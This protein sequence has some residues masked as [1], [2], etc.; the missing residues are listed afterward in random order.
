MT[1]EEMKARLAQI[2]AELGEYENLED[3][4]DEQLESINALHEESEGL[5]KKIETKEKLK[6]TLA[7]ANTSKRQTSA[8]SSAP[9]AD[10]E[11]GEDRKKL[12]PKAG[13]K[14]AGEFFSAVRKASNPSN[15][16]KRLLNT[17]QERYADEGGFLIPED[18]RNDIRQKVTGDESLLSRTLQLNTSSNRI[19]FPTHEATPWGTGGIQAYWSGEKQDYTSSK[20]VFGKAGI[21]LHKLTAFVPVTDELLDDAAALESFIR[22]QAPEAMLHKVNSAIING[23][24]VGKPEGFLNSGFKVDVAEESGQNADTVVYENIVKMQAHILPPAFARSVWL[25]HPSVIPQ[26]R[27]M[28]F[29]SSA[30]SPVPAY[31]PPAGLAEAPYGTLMGRPILPMMGG[32]Q[33][34]GDE[35][36]ICLV[37]LGYYIS[38]VKTEGI[39][40]DYSQHVY[41][42]RDEV[43]FKFSMRIGGLVPFQNPVTTENGSFEMSGI[44]TLQ[45]R[46]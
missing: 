41:F 34:L 4:T 11:V 37:D 20:P 33:T 22:M 9:K 8:P 24:G 42:D 30:T 17:A 26:L 32:L 19:T 2:V 14:S 13:F 3:Y 44:V 27:L 46:A 31:M 15:M 7:K 35:G 6:N 23:D 10:V 1:I 16:D 21:D 36:D 40:Q 39:K 5:T 18:F 28:A 43:A 25:V 12:D 29:D 45:D 38:A